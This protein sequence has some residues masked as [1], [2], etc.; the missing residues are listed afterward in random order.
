MKNYSKMRMWLVEKKKEIGIILI[1]F[2][3][4]YII[5]FIFFITAKYKLPMHSN[6]DSSYS[7]FD[8]FLSIFKNNFYVFILFLLGSVTYGFL[9]YANLITN[10][11]VLAF[12]TYWFFELG[13]LSFSV[14]VHGIPEFSAFFLAAILGLKSVKYHLLNRRSSFSILCL[15]VFLVLLG[16]ILETYVSPLILEHFMS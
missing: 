13:V 11:V 7:S 2:L 14:I 16:S 9:T 6:F 8:T 5:S 3:T 12:A 4:L 15:G 1:L 10:A